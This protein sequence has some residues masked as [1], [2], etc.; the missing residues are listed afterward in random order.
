MIQYPKVAADLK[1]NGYKYYESV[2]GG[3]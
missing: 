3:R 2:H 1:A